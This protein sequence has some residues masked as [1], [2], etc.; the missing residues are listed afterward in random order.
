MFFR[1]IKVEFIH[2]NFLWLH[3]LIEINVLL[4]DIMNRLLFLK[5][6]NGFICSCIII[7]LKMVMV[8]NRYPYE[9][10]MHTFRPFGYVEV[11]RVNFP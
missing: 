8:L 3:L 9:I 11:F 5:L 2:I 1:S 4:L 7:S 6:S 10:R